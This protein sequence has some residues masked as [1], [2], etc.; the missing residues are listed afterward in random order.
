MI[1]SHDDVLMM[2]QCRKYREGK[3]EI[4]SIHHPSKNANYLNW[5]ETTQAYKGG[6]D[7]HNQ[8]V[9]FPMKIRGSGQLMLTSNWLDWWKDLS[10]QGQLNR[11]L[12]STYINPSQLYACQTDN[13]DMAQEVRAVVWQSEGCRF[14]S[15]PPWACRSLPEQ[16]TLHGSQSPL[17]CECVC[18]WVNERHKLYSTLNKGAI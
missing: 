17:V 3:K 10:V 5:W 11:S 4:L 2:K 13:G 14:G 8:P 6:I 1:N 18:E 12:I 16:D 9:H 7:T 15:I